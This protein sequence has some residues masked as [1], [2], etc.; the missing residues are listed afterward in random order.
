M[1]LQQH[2]SALT[3][4][5]ITADCFS[6]RPAACSR[7]HPLSPVTA[8]TSCQ[9]S[10]VLRRPLL[11]TALGDSSLHTP[12]P[13]APALRASRLS[14]RHSVAASQTAC[15]C[16]PRIPSRVLAR[17]HQTPLLSPHRSHTIA[18]RG[19][20]RGR[21]ASPGFA[22]MPSPRSPHGGLLTHCGPTRCHPV[23]NSYLLPLLPPRTF[24]P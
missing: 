24:S 15:R 2:L 10:L 20:P 7:Q 19:Q 12:R 3:S 5:Y 4:K 1:S 14:K 11:N 6:A 17:P 9:H 13:M 23:P 8:E 21:G 18:R 16:W 22:C